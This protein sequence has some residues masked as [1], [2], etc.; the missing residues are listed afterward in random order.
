[1]SKPDPEVGS[2]PPPFSEAAAEAAPSPSSS[3]MAAD[4]SNVVDSSQMADDPPLDI[5]DADDSS[6]EENNLVDGANKLASAMMELL[7]TEGSDNTSSG[8]KQQ[9]KARAA[10]AGADP[11]EFAP[12]GGG[13]SGTTRSARGAVDAPDDEPPSLRAATPPPAVDAKPQDAVEAMRSPSSGPSVSEF[14][15]LGD[16]S[17]SAK[18]SFADKFAQRGMD[19]RSSAQRFTAAASNGGDDIYQPSLTSSRSV[20]SNSPGGAGSHRRT[21]S[22]RGLRTLS[23]K[24]AEK[25]QSILKNSTMTPPRTKATPVKK[26]S[27]PDFVSMMEFQFITSLLS[28]LGF[29]SLISLFLNFLPTYRTTQTLTLFSGQAFDSCRQPQSPSRRKYDVILLSAELLRCS[30]PWFGFSASFGGGEPS[31]TC[32]R[33]WILPRRSRPSFEGGL[34]A[35]HW[36]MST[37]VLH[38]CSELCADTLPVSECT[39]CSMISGGTD[40]PPSYRQHGER[41]RPNLAISSTLSILS[42][43]RA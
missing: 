1:M 42:L 38:S 22:G 19:R 24:K 29:S 25:P 7:G 20:S 23:S 35:I 14:I 12:I 9:T 17:L 30:E 43:F 26:A 18:P 11:F 21:L 16:P 40:R 36:K 13:Q 6:D 27:Q 41:T 34:P 3:P 10:A 2:D 39:R 5:V 8:A 4:R 33:M 28:F 37:T 32:G 31:G 15:D